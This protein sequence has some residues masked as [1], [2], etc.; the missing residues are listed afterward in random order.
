MAKQY[1]AY[2]DGACV[3]N[4]GCGGWAY[5]M[6]EC[7]DGHLGKIGEN[8]GGERNTTNNR[9]ELLAVIGALESLPD[10]AAIEVRTDSRLVML[11]AMRRWK[12]KANGDLWR[13]YDM[14][15]KGR[16][17]GWKWVK[18]H[19]GDQ[20]NERADELAS[21][22]VWRFGGGQQIADFDREWRERIA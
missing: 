10:G 5:V 19:N 20:W 2:T 18:G 22:A 6:F 14:A 9:M 11:C 1:V 3:P 4:P 8:S 21:Q 7:Q 17:V 13:R 16:K 15:A 12:R